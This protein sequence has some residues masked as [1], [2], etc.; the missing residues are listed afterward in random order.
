MADDTTDPAAPGKQTTEFKVSVVAGFLAS[1]VALIALI[2]PGFAVDPAVQRWIATVAVG[3][4]G[5]VSKAYTDSRASVKKSLVDERTTVQ[6]A[7]LAP[8]V[9]IVA[10][11]LPATQN[12]ENTEQTQPVRTTSAPTPGVGSGETHPGGQF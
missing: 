1:L 11:P 6:V 4:L 8:P 2:H 3:V 5:L 10:A 12:V 9:N 7:Q